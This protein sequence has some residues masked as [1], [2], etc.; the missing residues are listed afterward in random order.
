MNT[1]FVYNKKAGNKFKSTLINEIKANL[2]S[3]F[4]SAFVE[5][6]KFDTFKT[7][8]FECLVAVGGDGTVNT[9]AKRACTEKKVLAIIPHGSGDGLARF[10]GLTKNIATDV[11][12]ILTGH[13]IQ[14]DT[15]DVSD[16]FFINVAGTGFEAE[17]ADTFDKSGI[18]GI[19]G[20]VKTIVKLFYHKKEEYVSLTLPSTKVKLPFFSL[21]IANGNQWGNNFEIA[22]KADIQDG[23]LEIAIMRKPKWYQIPHLILFLK[24][25]RKKSPLITYYQAN[26][27][28][29]EQESGTWHIDGEPIQ[30][31]GRKVVHIHPKNLTII[32]P[33]G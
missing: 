32:V 12:T 14:I 30:L 6:K 24:N 22:S 4:Q 8:D 18:R 7:N 17:V 15:A 28:T 1:L 11:K 26:K 2:P 10:L 27:I 29:I 23:L 9:L 31:K 3:K 16:H 20:Y 5:I 21:S 19:L 25:K 13:K 33:H